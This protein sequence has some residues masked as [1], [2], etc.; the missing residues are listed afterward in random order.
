MSLEADVLDEAFTGAARPPRPWPT[1]SCSD[2][3]AVSDEVSLVLNDPLDGFAF[4]ELEGAY[5]GEIGHAF[6]KIFGHP[7]RSHFGHFPER[8]DARGEV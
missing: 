6:R 8:S 7:F 3:G 5:F 1:Y 2:D 4:L